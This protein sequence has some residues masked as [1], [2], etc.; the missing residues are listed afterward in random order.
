MNSKISRTNEITLIMEVA[1]REFKIPLTSVS[2]NI[3]SVKRILNG[4]AQNSLE[5]LKEKIESIEV[6]T[7]NM[8]MLLEHLLDLA[9]IQISEIQ[10]RKHLTHTHDLLTDVLAKSKKPSDP[11]FVSIENLDSN[12]YC[13]IACDKDRMIQ[14]FSSLIINL[15][16]HDQSSGT[17]M[18]ST[19]SNGKFAQFKFFDQHCILNENYLSSI[20]DN[21]WYYKSK[22]LEKVG[23]GLALSKWIIEA[24]QG[25][26]WIESNAEIGTAF[27]IELPKM[28]LADLKATSL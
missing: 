27:Y 8:S 25:K 17:V 24:H 6:T 20:F 19:K 4:E 5:L 14:V 7:N 11:Q 26:I 16:S 3:Q 10:M 12:E 28:D 9:K 18:M 2:F 23:L 22:N 21:F 13:T 1:T 15:N